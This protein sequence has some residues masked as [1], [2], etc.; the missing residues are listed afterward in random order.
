M[1]YVCRSNKSSEL[2]IAVSLLNWITVIHEMMTTLTT[3]LSYFTSFC[4]CSLELVSRYKVYVISVSG[5][6]RN[7]NVVQQYLY[8]GHV[9][10]TKLLTGC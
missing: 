9:N 8:C 6:Q 4:L 10:Y 2:W 1:W 3:S 5:E 7:V